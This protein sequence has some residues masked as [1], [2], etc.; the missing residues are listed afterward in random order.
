M[1]HRFV[2]LIHVVDNRSLT[3]YEINLARKDKK[4]IARVAGKSL[5]ERDPVFITLNSGG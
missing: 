5:G 1:Q 2:H 3:Q 4:Q